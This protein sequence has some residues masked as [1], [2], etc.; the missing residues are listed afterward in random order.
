MLPAYTKAQIYTHHSKKD[1]RK[2]IQMINQS[3]AKSDVTFY[4]VTE[5]AN[6]KNSCC[7]VRSFL[8]SK[9]K[10]KKTTTKNDFI[11]CVWLWILGWRRVNEDK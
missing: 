1:Y 10:D 8:M 7:Y 11:T 3:E 2:L 4:H 5:L 6:S 9:K